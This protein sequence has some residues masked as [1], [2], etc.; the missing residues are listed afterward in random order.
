MN[1]HD[2][3][4]LVILSRK[5][6]EDIGLVLIRFL[7]GQLLA[8]H[9]LYEDT[10]SLCLIAGSEGN[11]VKTVIGCAASVSL[12]EINTLVQCADDI[13]NVIHGMANDL[14]KLGHVVG[15]ALLLNIHGLVGAEGRADLEA[16][17]RDLRKLLMPLQR[18]DRII[19][20]SDELNIGLTNDAANSQ[21]RVILKE[22]GCF[23]PDFLCILGSQ[24]LLDAEILLQLQIAPVVHR[25]ADGH[26]KS[27]CKSKELLIG[28][29]IAGYEVLRSAV[30]AHHSPLVVIAEIRAV[31]AAAAEP[32]L[33]DVVVAAILIDLL[34]RDVAVIIDDRKLLTVIM[35]Q[36]P[37]CFIVEHEIL[38]HKSVHC[39]L[40]LSGGKPALS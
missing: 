27:L 8:G 31:C 6:K 22:L 36:V 20:G 16:K 3:V 33:C 29:C 4:L 35:K 10:V 39:A 14:G 11:V 7:A 2:D 17:I 15:E 5:G 30:A 34:R 9:R 40:V 21:V 37:G 1:L 25:I 23:V 18:I 28:L 13:G 26:L 24:S 32:D 12:E 38:V 19:G